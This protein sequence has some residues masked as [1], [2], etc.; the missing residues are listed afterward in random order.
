MALFKT[1]VYYVDN[2][3]CRS[4][5]LPSEDELELKQW[6]AED[7]GIIHNLRLIS[8]FFPNVVLYSSGTDLIRDI[9]ET[10]KRDPI[11][12]FIDTT[13]DTSNK[14]HGRP[15]EDNKFYGINLLQL[16]DSRY[17]GSI[18][19]KLYIVA[20]VND[21][22]TQMYEFIDCGAMDVISYRMELSRLRGI[23]SQ[24]YRESSTRNSTRANWIGG[25]LQKFNS[26]DDKLIESLFS[27][28]LYDK[29]FNFDTLAKAPTTQEIPSGRLV[30]LA[31]QIGDWDF[32]VESLTDD[33]LY[34]CAYLIFK[35]SF[36][37]PEVS[38]LI[39]ND[40]SL[41]QFLS[42]LRYSYQPHNPYHNFRHAVDVL[43]ATF[44]FLLCMR[45]LPQ[46]AGSDSAVM[47]RDTECS[48]SKVLNQRD[49]LALLVTALGHD[50]GHPGVTNS[51]LVASRSPLARMYHD[52]SV[53]ESF[54]CATFNQIL[55]KYWPKI[56]EAHELKAA[57][58][59]AVLATDMAMHM[60]YM[61]RLSLE[62]KNS[63]YSASIDADHPERDK[64]RRLLCCLL[65]KCA[66]ISNVSRSL[67][68]SSYWGSVLSL[69]FQNMS[70]MEIY[71]GIK[72]APHREDQNTPVSDL[73]NQ[74]TLAKGQ[75][76]FI[77]TFGQ[78]L[79]QAVSDVLPELAFTAVNAKRN[80]DYWDSELKRLE[81]LNQQQHRAE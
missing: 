16:L 56:H 7:E 54:H 20:L 4:G 62:L 32:H 67:E 53:L 71:L 61:K 22:E 27:I 48:F 36:T 50:V 43:Q 25:S 15:G 65:M 79:F 18:F 31:S 46:Y 39:L 5:P 52:D 34:Y 28:I 3:V 17:S 12:V 24:L 14:E 30:Y 73:L 60:D 23:M 21:E 10:D 40:D 74:I 68:I 6:P 80:K 49:A 75:S 8:K 19:Y 33:D 35:H 57:I 11:V 41:L 44:Y 51:F 26:D 59:D 72:Q 64:I 69:E 55:Y 45:S 42:I 70:N 63:G 13:A 38:D 81:S 78:P 66:D 37:M 47:S 2:R 1:R 9:E 76:F 77:S 29:S 58:V